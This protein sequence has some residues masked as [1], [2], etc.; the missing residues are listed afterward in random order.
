[1]YGYK[2]SEN[3]ELWCS[4]SLYDEKQQGS[5]VKQKNAG[6]TRIRSRDR[7]RAGRQGDC[8]RARHCFQTLLLSHIPTSSNQC[9]VFVHVTTD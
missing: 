3:T 7:M 1:M 9:L 5:C 8:A 6:L 2:F 4:S